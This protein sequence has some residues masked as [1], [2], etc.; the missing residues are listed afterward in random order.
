MKDLSYEQRRI[1]K[2]FVVLLIIVCV[3]LVIDIGIRW[4]NNYKTKK[5]PIETIELNGVSYT[6]EVYTDGVVKAC[7]DEQARTIVFYGHGAIVNPY[8]WC[9]LDS[10]QRRMVRDIIVSDGITYIGRRAFNNDVLGFPC[11]NLES[12]TIE[13]DLIEIGEWA[14]WGNPALET[15]TF[16]GDCKNIEKEAFRGLTK[17][18]IIGIDPPEEAFGD[19]NVFF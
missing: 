9:R 13:G 14:F 12:V 15:I 18:N 19:N 6:G 3:I 1:K 7:F 11:D 5:K 16:K 4:S 2:T 17:E 10:S 8:E